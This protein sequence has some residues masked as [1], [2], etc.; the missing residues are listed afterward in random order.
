MLYAEATF[1]LSIYL[2]KEHFLFGF[3]DARVNKSNIW[4]CSGAFMF[5]KNRSHDFVN[6]FQENKND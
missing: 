2:L 4:L 3:I 6:V 5:M 1:L